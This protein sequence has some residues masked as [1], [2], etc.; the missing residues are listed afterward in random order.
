MVLTTAS[1]DNAPVS[2]LEAAAAGL[3]VVAASVGGQPDLAVDGDDALLVDGDDPAA[4][5]T[6]VR[7]LVREP[8][9]ATRL[10]ANGRRLAQGSGWARARGRWETVLT[11][12]AAR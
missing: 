2:A 4:L 3:P 8:G 5:A 12:V 9:L 11:S 10:P 7:R 6:A 1:V